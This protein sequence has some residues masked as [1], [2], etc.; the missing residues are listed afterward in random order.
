MD[1]LI[2]SI[3]FAIRFDIHSSYSGYFWLCPLSP[4][5]HSMNLLL[6]L[7]HLLYFSVIHSLWPVEIGFNFMIWVFI[8]G[9]R[10][11][12]QS[13]A[14]HYQL[15][16]ETKLAGDKSSNQIFECAGLIDKVAQWRRLVQL[17]IIFILN[18]WLRLSYLLKGVIKLLAAYNKTDLSRMQFRGR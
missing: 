11:V 17:R 4:S 3:L 18:F 7:R 15:S 12:T 10:K 6:F 9:I 2:V 1:N 14:D 5:L 13:P 8:A 16:R